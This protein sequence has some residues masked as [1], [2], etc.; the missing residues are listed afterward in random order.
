M[1]KRNENPGRVGTRYDQPDAVEDRQRKSMMQQGVFIDYTCPVCGKNKGRMF[2]H[3]R[4]SKIMQAR[5]NGV[6]NA[7]ANLERP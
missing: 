6:P 4:C 7:L 1:T 3:E 2:N 5:R